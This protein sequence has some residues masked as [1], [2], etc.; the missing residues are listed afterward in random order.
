[1][2]TKKIFMA[3]IICSM[4]LRATAAELKSGEYFITQTW[5]QESNYKRPYYVNVPKNAGTQRL[6]VF[7][8]LHGNGGNAQGA[9]RGFLRPHKP[10]QERFIMVFPQGYQRSWNI[11]SERSKA[12]DLAY[13]ESIIETVSSYSNVQNDNFSIMGSSNGAA[14]VNQIAIETK[15]A[16]IKNYISAVSPLNTYQHDG[17]HF[18]SKGKDNN[19]TEITVPLTHKRLM[20]ISGTKDQLIPYAGGHSRGIR[21]KNGKLSFVSAEQSTFLWAKQMGYKGKQLTE[22]TTVDG[23]IETFSYLNGDVVHYKVINAAHNAGRA[24]KEDVLLKFLE[25]GRSK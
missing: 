25:G 11:V 13:I 10:M 9:M 22:P 6:P 4:M 18:K 5:S 2:T 14:L 21:A 20:N 15:L 23:N 8:F 24:I 3:L 1:M 7:I 19:Y 17:K 16:C 12:D